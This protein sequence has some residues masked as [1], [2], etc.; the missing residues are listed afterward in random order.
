MKI[1]FVSIYSDS[2]TQDSLFDPKVYYLGEN[3]SVSGILLR[4][5]LVR[6]GDEVHTIDMFDDYDIALFQDIPVDSWLVIHTLADRLRY[7]L[8]RK[9]RWDY[10]MQ[11]VRRLPKE[12]RILQILEPAT[13]APQSYDKRLHQYFDRIL[14]WDDDLVD[15]KV[16]FKYFIPQYWDHTKLARP[17][18]EK[19]KYVIMASNKTSRDPNELY[20]RRRAVIDYF[21]GSQ[22]D[23]FDLYGFGWEDQGLRNYKGSVKKKLLTLSGYRFCFCFENMAGVNGY[24]TEKLFDCLFSGC[25]PVYL[26]AE[27]VLDYIPKDVFVDARMFGSIDKLVNHLENMTEATYAQYLSAAWDFL[28]SEAF[29]ARFSIENYVNTVEAFIDME[30]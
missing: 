3:L 16:Y 7:I 20:S 9:W 6:R 18:S 5:S 27:N 17:Y 10:L 24:I 30:R 28:N 8:R 1:A 2:R 14:T 13:V 4:D 19:K 15:H 25:V 29:S 21:E 22:T 23:D 26:G 11:A 12:K